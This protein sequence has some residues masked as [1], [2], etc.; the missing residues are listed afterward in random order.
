MIYPLVVLTFAILMLIGMLLFLV[1]VFQRSSRIWR[2]PADADE[3]RRRASDL[4]RGYWFILFPA[5]G[6]SVWGFRRWKKTP[7]GRQVW[8]RFK[9]RV[10]C[11]SA[12]SC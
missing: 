8:D 3:G 9:L 2:R 11:R 5:M 12:T 10:P 7:A 1:P 6:P 4:V